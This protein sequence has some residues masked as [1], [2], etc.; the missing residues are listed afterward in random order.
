MNE[1]YRQAGR[2]S[3]RS[4]PGAAVAGTD[5]AAVARAAPVAPAAGGFACTGAP[6]AG[7]GPAG[8]AAGPVAGR[9]RGAEV[10]QPGGI[11]GAT[12]GRWPA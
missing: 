4:T 10:G 12:S 3:S 8:P 9:H 7:R 2:C 6:A 1:A 11:E 5:V